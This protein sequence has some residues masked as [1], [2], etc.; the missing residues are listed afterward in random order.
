[1][2]ESVKIDLRGIRYEDM[3]WIQLAQHRVLWL[4]LNDHGNDIS[5]SI[6]AG[7]S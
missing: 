3:D 7:M 4:V 1:M 5:G 2:G 6:N